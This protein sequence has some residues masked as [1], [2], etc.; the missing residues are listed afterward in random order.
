MRTF[1]QVSTDAQRPLCTSAHEAEVFAG[2]WMALGNARPPSR[3]SEWEKKNMSRLRARYSA[4][5]RLALSVVLA[6]RRR[7]SRES[8]AA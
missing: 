4:E 7:I 1:A 8:F 3:S 5:L 6:P 2:S